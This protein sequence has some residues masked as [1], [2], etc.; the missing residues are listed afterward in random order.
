MDQIVR[1]QSESWMLGSADKAVV[2]TKRRTSRLS[3]AVLLLFYRT[4][5]RFPRHALD[6]EAETI[7]AVARQIG[8]PVEPFDIIDLGDR[9][10]KRH[11]AEIRTLLGFREATVADGEALTEW[12]SHH[13]VTSSTLAG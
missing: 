3:F 6:I 2:V 12:L 7:V 10:L 5:G 13:A 11:R 9:T 8:A 1:D 4:H